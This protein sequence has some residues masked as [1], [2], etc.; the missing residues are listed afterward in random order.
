[1]KYKTGDVV[2]LKSK[3]ELLDEFFFSKTGSY[4]LLYKNEEYYYKNCFLF[5]I[6]DSMMKFLGKENKIQSCYP[7]GSYKISGCNWPECAI[8]QK[9]D[10]DIAICYIKKEIGI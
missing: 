7:A 6:H 9:T 4:L 10:F 3:E 8:R 2:T 1:M 5:S